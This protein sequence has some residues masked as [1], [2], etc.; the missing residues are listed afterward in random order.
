[1]PH[2]PR[3]G[4]LE[5]KLFSSVQNSRRGGWWW[6]RIDMLP[7]RITGVNL[8]HR[9]WQSEVSCQQRFRTESNL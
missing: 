1:M 3:A 9:R 7:R 2:R 5:N 6:R 8:W 4:S